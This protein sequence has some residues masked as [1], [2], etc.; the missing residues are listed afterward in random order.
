MKR[1]WTLPVILLLAG[2][3]SVPGC[4]E[5]QTEETTKSDNGK[6]GQTQTEP[7]S[8]SQPNV[9]TDALSEAEAQQAQ[10]LING[11]VRYLLERQGPGG[12][13]TFGEGA[14]EPAAT[15]LV[16]NVLVRHP[17]FDHDDPV[18]KKAFDAMLKYRQPDGGIYDPEVGLANYTTSIAIMALTSAGNPDHKPI[19]DEAVKFLKGLQVTAGEETPAGDTISEDHP[20]FGGFGY[21]S[22]NERPDGSNAGMAVEALKQAGVDPNSEVMQNARVFLSRM[23]NRKE[24]NPLEWAQQG[25]NDGGF[26]YA[27]AKA[28]TS[29]GE[30]K[31]GPAQ[32]GGLRSYGSLTYAAFKSM[33]HAGLERDDPRVRDALSWIKGH[34]TFERN[35]G[36]PINQDRKH[37]LQ[38]LYYYYNMMAKA[39]NAW[40]E[41]TITDSDGNEHNWRAE[42]IDALAKRVRDNGSWVN[43]GHERWLESDPVL[44]TCYA[45]GA[46]QETIRK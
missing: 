44:V 16:I 34:W 39:L 12:G 4:G 3:L 13:W 27:P 41:P 26:I 32:G 40:G 38:G 21:G 33:L 46:L 6:D 35:P 45:T 14:Y 7:I 19:I 1:I 9:E 2:L 23:Q 37:H 17:D 25:P 22:K 29:V 15:G 36:M 11:G 28:D 30:S 24:T 20:Y 43:T 10:N 42:L 5:D 8:L 18:I 31:A